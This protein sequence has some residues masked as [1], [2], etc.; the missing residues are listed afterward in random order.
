MKATTLRRMPA[1]TRGS[2]R[3]CIRIGR[4]DSSEIVM[5]RFRRSLA[6]VAVGLM[7]G[8]GGASAQFSNTFIFGDSLSDAGQYG[9]RFTTNPGLTFP[10]YVAQ[11]FGLTATPSFTGGND[12]AQGGAML[13]VP[14][15]NLPPGTP[16]FTITQQVNNFIAA[17]RVDPNALYQVNGG[18]NDLTSLVGQAA[19]GQI[20]AAQAQAGVA[21][22]AVDLA[23]LAARL[24]A[25]GARYIV[26]YGLPDVGLVPDAAALHAQATLTALSDLFNTTLDAALQQAHAQ[27]IRVNS[28]ALLREVVANPTAFGFVNVTSPV[29]TTSSALNCT[30]STLRDPSGNLTWA[31]ADGEHPTT[32]LALIGAQVA[33]SMIEAPAKIG[34]LGEAPLNVEAAAF[35]NIDARMIGAV[36]APAPTYK[37]NPWV[38]YD[39]GSRDMTGPFVSGDSRANTI[40]VGGDMYLTPQFL[41]G[42]AFNYTEDRQDFGAD[43]GGFKLKETA[44][45]FYAGYGQGP[46]WFGATLGAGDLRYDDIHRNIQLGSLRRVETASTGG[47]HVMAS[48]LGG[49]WFTYRTLLHGPFVRFA[50]QDINVNAFSENGSDS[51]ALSY[52]EQSRKSFITSAGWQATGQLGMTRPFARVTWEFEGKDDDRNVTATPLGSTL[53][54]SMPTLKP[55]DNYVRYLVGI[56][57]D[58]GRVT[59]YITGE[60]TSS[61]GEG[62]G[63][64]VTVGV[65]VPL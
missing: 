16:N 24:Q 43:T 28:A 26:V 56:A 65:R 15:D 44:A 63:Y 31:F 40:A 21:Q 49:Y 39:Y 7:L 25:A 48:V 33:V 62:N 35:R 59:G 9:A 20:T 17:G 32:G 29:C 64:A 51:T 57:S 50:W 19:A 52:G 54:Y 58:F 36:G 12:F 41:V 3:D 23:T 34:M 42:V 38:S 13:N 55:D 4:L 37:Y 2:R 22:A 8:S 5:R 46:W 11:A 45:T 53:S 60:G 30:P 27:V 1:L 6:A 10:M 14:A 61:R 47:S 18:G